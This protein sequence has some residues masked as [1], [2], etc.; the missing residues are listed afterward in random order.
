MYHPE[1]GSFF[2]T[3]IGSKKIAVGGYMREE[4]I[5]IFYLFYVVENT[6]GA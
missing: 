5:T 6:N 4:A 2:T 3:G 1:L